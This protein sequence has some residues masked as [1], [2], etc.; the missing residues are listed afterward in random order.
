M[1]RS[2]LDG[3]FQ[4]AAVESYRMAPMRAA[5]AVALAALAGFGVGWTS[6]LAWLAAVAATEVAAFFVTRPMASAPAS[7]PRLA[8]YFW[9]SNF[10]VPAWSLYGLILWTGHS[11]ACAL[12]AAAQ[13]CGQLLYAQNFCTKSPVQAVQAGIPSIAMPL[14]VPVLLPRFHGMDQVLVMCMLALAVGHAVIAAMD[15]MKTGRQLDAATRALVAGKQAAEAAEARMAEAKAEAEAANAAKSAFL[16]TMSHEIRTPL[17]GVLGMTQAMAMHRLSKAQRARLAV[18]SASGEALLTILNDVLDLAKIE[19][20]KLTLEDIEFDLGEVVVGAASAFSALAAQKGLTLAVDVGAAEGTYRGDPTRLRQI[21]LNLISNA[22][23]FT[24]EGRIDVTATARGGRLS[25]AVADSGEGIAPELLHSLF[26]KFTQADASTARR[27]GGTG[28]GLAICHQ[29]AE[30]MGGV[31]E[32]DSR[33]GEG[34]TFT[35]T[36]AAARVGEARGVPTASDEPSTNE[37]ERLEGLRVLA[38]EDN[39][40]N[41]LVLKTL[42]EHIDVHPVFVENGAEAVE[43]WAQGSWDLV[44][45]DVSMPVMDGPTAVRAIRAR[46]AAEHRPRTPIIALTANAMAHQIAEYMAGGMDGHIAKPIEAAKLF[47][48]ITAALQSSSAGARADA[49]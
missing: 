30:L 2:L 33:L 18:V 27:F 6:A 40:T 34:S 20:G 14:L 49:A 1:L 35:V 5:I 29:L 48:A 7:Y 15:V 43:A 26:A 9:C 12:A 24:H 31:I 42:L 47:E 41:Q 3:R 21:V 23:K 45:M 13:W 46:E 39:Q 11:E 17:N 19:A 8:A 44:L 37:A 28:L 22:L 32:V 16:A 36:I 10:G 25:I 38:A 4:A